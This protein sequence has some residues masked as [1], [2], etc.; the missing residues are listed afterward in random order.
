MLIKRTATTSPL[1]GRKP[2]MLHLFSRPTDKTDGMRA[3]LV[4]V[5]WECADVDVC[6]SSAA[7]DCYTSPRY[8]IADVNFAHVAPTADK[9][10]AMK[11]NASWNVRL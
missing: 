3:I 5:G 1:S 6:K 10:N 4:R 9:H 2:T 11:H 8:G 7:T